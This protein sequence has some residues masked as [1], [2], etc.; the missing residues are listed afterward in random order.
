M[1]TSGYRQETAR[2]CICDSEVAYGEHLMEYLKRA[3]QLPFD[4][5]LYTNRYV[6]MS[7]ECPGTVKLLVIAES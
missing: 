1:N 4:I 2:I 3:G 7:R 6:F 5:Y